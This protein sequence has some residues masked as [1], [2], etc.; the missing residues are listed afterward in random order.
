MFN[1]LELSD[2]KINRETRYVVKSL[3]T[4]RG[5]SHHPDQSR[6]SSL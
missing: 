5:K 2:H 3:H 1:N 6:V 4:Q